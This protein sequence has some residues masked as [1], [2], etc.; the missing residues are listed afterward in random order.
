[1]TLV[2]GAVLSAFVN[3]T[4]IVVLLLPILISVCLRNATSPIGILMPMGFATLVGGMA[5]TVGT[6]TNLLVVSVARDLGQDA[7]G[8]FDFAL[9]A[10]I[11][12]GVAIV[13]LWLI[14]PRLLPARNIDLANPSPRLFEARLQIDEGSPFSGRILAD[15]MA[16]TDGDM[17]VTRIRRGDNFILPLPD[18]VLKEGDRLRVR[19]TPSS[20][21]NFESALG[22]SLYSEDQRSTTTIRSQPTIRC[23]RRSPWSRAQP[24]TART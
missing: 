19:D 8:M 9:P 5:T 13:Y 3:N 4:P 23:W 11:A 2:V 20:L 7:I 18:V 6:S 22:A 24:S 16:A 17:Q 1:M 15:A 10:A 21:K 14:A 12:G